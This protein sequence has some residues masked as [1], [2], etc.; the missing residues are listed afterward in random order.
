MDT[1]SSLQPGT[2]SSASRSSSES[3]YV[4]SQ[5][6]ITTVPARSG[7]L[8]S[9]RQHQV[10]SRLK[11]NVSRCPLTSRPILKVTRPSESAEGKPSA[12][13]KWW[14]Y[15]ADD[16]EIVKHSRRS[17]KPRCAVFATFA[18][19]S[20]LPQVDRAAATTCVWRPACNSHR[21]AAMGSASP[22]DLSMGVHVRPSLAPR[23]PSARHQVSSHGGI[24]RRTGH[25]I[26]ALR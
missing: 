7:L 25:A 9:A 22:P 11:A 3:V 4:P 24:P 12:I 13:G 20:R 15:L 5:T 14:I 26:P 16:W 10:S 18:K 8:S 6:H 2:W 1:A 19:H 17:W 23:Q 21:S